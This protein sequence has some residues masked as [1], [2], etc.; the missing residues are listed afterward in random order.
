MPTSEGILSWATAVA[1]DWRWLAT[2]WHLGL[3][4][5]LI[6][7]AMVRPSRRLIGA[8][9]VLPVLSVAV[10]AWASGNP[11]NGLTFTL[12]AVLLLRAAVHL[13]RISFVPASP[14]W[15]LAGA[16]LVAFGWVYPHFL[17]TGSWTDYAYASP[18]GLLPCPTL[19]VVVGITLICGGLSSVA[20]SVP[21]AAAGVLYGLIGV[22]FLRVALDVWLL[23][24][25]LLLSFV[26]VAHLGGGRVRA[27]D[28]E[29]AR[30]LP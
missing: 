28:E 8:G 24:G 13:P 6:W 27:T 10:V 21:V 15:M 19:A 2:L 9:L 3:A 16:G 26:S 30:V 22:F 4:A 17:V 29:R 12:L 5:A 1:N 14:G 18:F 25:A 23:G 11:F 7:L 20:W